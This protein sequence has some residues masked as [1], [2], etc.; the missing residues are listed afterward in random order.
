MDNKIENLDDWLLNNEKY[1]Q[2]ER[3]LIVKAIEEF[4]ADDRYKKIDCP[5]DKCDVC[6]DC[7]YYPDYKFNDKTGNCE[8]NEDK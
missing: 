1:S 8:N 6:G 5:L 3:E 2:E 4:F 7:P